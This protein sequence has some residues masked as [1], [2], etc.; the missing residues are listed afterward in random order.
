MLIKYRGN[1]GRRINGFRGL[2]MQA[3][4]DSHFKHIS[5]IHMESCFPGSTP[6]AFPPSMGLSLL[7]GESEGPLLPLAELYPTFPLAS[8]HPFD[9]CSDTP[10]PSQCPVAQ[11]ATE[12]Q[13]PAQ[14]PPL[15]QSIC[16][17]Q[18]KCFLYH[19]DLS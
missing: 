14:H 3:I 2:S 15:P 10:C 12:Q 11:A 18:A 7:P 17:C 9:L 6:N 4:A 16:R 5:I 8:V 1:G 19:R 13:P